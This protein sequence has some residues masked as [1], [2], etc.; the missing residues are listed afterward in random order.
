V[1]AQETAAAFSTGT[2]V[3]KNAEVEAAVGDIVSLLESYPVSDKV[4]KVSPS[5][6][7]KLRAHYNSLSY[8]AL[9]SS[10]KAS[11]NL[12]KRRVCTRAGTGFLFAQHPLFEVDVQLSVPSVRLSPNLSEVQRAINRCAVAIIGCSKHV[13]QWGQAQIPELQKRPFF[14][15]LGCDMEI[16][17]VSL[18]LTGALHGTKATVAQY[19]STLRKYDWIWKEDKDEAYE[20]FAKTRPSTADFEAELRRFVILEGEIDGIVSSHA[21]GALSLQTINLQVQ[22]RNELRQWKIQ[23]AHKVHNQA[24]GAMRN[25]SDYI[26]V[27]HEKLRLEVWNIDNLRYVMGVLREVRERDASIELEIAPIMDLYK[28]LEKYLPGSLV[29][30]DELDQAYLMRPSWRKM[31]T[32]A[33][34]V[35]DTLSELQTRLKKQLLQDVKDF[36]SEVR[37][38]RHDFDKN[39][40]LVRGITPGEAAERLEKFRG[41]LEALELRMETYCAGEELFALPP[42]QYRELTRTR[43]EVDLLDQLYSLYLDVLQTSEVFRNHKWIEVSGHIAKMRDVIAD[44][45]ARSKKL[46]KSLR[47]WKAYHEV[48]EV[49]TVFRESVPLMVELIKPSVKTRHWAEVNGTLGAALPYEDEHSFCVAH[50][51][52]SPLTH[53]KDEV[54]EICNGAEK[55]LAIET[56]LG[57]IKEHWDHRALAFTPWKVRAVPVLTGPVQVLEELSDATIELQAQLSSPHVAPFRE[58]VQQKLKTLSDTSETLDLWVKVQTSWCSLESVFVGSN[59]AKQMPFEAKKFAKVCDMRWFRLN[60]LIVFLLLWYSR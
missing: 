13:W 27:T 45:D 57:D 60:F 18:L 43:K 46:P 30:K 49:I 42:T 48:N 39:G 7:K 16:I 32:F 29:G 55:E 4:E 28:L 34:G 26:K 10:T 50:L 59:I 1:L 6:L 40:P 2:L 8:R 20:R 38:F 24:G 3:D 53:F 56:K 51:L 19:L 11:L 58:A 35:A 9:L 21:I 14:D 15:I 41:E 5:A 36:V 54:K 25:L 47:D 44:F 23:Y 22:L 31:V 33:E 17:K 52:E 37:D 12:L